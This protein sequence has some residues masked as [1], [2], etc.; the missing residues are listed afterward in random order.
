VQTVVD[1][2]IDA[3]CTLHSAIFIMLPYGHDYEGPKLLIREEVCG[4]R[5]YY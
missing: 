2:F 3:E 4:L 5:N 1:I